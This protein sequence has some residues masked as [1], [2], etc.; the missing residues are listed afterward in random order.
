M[1]VVEV[2]FSTEIALSFNVHKL[3][4]VLLEEGSIL[5]LTTVGEEFVYAES[6]KSRKSLS[7][8]ILFLI[9]IWSSFEICTDFKRIKSKIRYV[10]CCFR[11]SG[12][13]D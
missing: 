1:E 11:V 2:V 7:A 4:W 5:R 12:G 9:G 8:K 10:N 13:S 6:G 3:F